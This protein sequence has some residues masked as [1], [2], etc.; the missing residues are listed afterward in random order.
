M[1]MMA[2]WGS[3]AIVERLA[4]LTA[5]LADGLRGVAV[6]VPEARV[7]APHILSLRFLDGMPNGLIKRLANENIHVA[8]RLGRMRISPHVYN[9]ESDID[10]FV[11]V[12]H[13]L[14]L[15]R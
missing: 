6:D 5:R 4:A 12:F 11:E 10:R 9:D 14:M 3:E 1:E 15:S 8:P 13:R 2:Q 7:R